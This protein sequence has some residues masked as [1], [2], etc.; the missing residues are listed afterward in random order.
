MGKQSERFSFSNEGRWVQMRAIGQFALAEAGMKGDYLTEGAMDSVVEISSSRED[1]GDLS[2]EALKVKAVHFAGR[3]SYR[4]RSH[5]RR[6]QS[7][8]ALSENG[9]AQ[10][11]REPVCREPGPEE[12]LQ[13]ADF[14]RRLLAPL[15]NFSQDQQKLFLD[16]VLRLKRFVDLE[17]ES[18]RSANALAQSTVNILRRLREMLEKNGIGMADVAE[19]LSRRDRGEDI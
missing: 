7:L 17:K 1:F 9:S 18:G 19:E 13:R 8:E 2:E 12:R 11:A 10:S 15:E 5:N 4:L 16:R 3:A 6:E 14:L